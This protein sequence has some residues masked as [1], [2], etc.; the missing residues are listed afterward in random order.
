MI[1]WL[2]LLLLLLSCSSRLSGVCFCLL[3]CV[4]V[5]VVVWFAWRCLCLCVWFVCVVLPVCVYFVCVML[6]CACVCG[7]AWC[8]LFV[9]G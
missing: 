9:C 1:A 3:G 4:C 2:C 7:C 5:V 6:M 8:L